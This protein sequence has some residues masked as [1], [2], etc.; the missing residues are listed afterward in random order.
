LALCLN[1][2]ALDYSPFDLRDIPT[3]SLFKYE[4]IKRA[5]EAGFKWL[6][7]RK[8]GPERAKVRH[9]KLI[10]GNKKDFTDVEYIFKKLE[11]TGS[12]KVQWLNDNGS[13]FL[14]FLKQMS[15]EVNL[16]CDRL[17]VRVS[18]DIMD[19]DYESFGQV[20]AR[21]RKLL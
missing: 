3:E 11:P 2:E 1:F 16:Q 6:N 8:R 17:L 7:N 21:Q 14:V 9:L 4:I 15:K 19:A 12:L 13:K 20:R 18:G 5:N 10:I